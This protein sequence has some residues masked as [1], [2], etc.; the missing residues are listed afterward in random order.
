VETLKFTSE[1][2]ILDFLS[3][4]YK[5]RNNSSIWKLSGQENIWR[6]YGISILLGFPAPFSAGWA[7][8]VSEQVSSKRY[9]GREVTDL[10]GLLGTLQPT[11]Q[12]LFWT[13]QHQPGCFP[14][15]QTRS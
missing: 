1:E 8:P 14:E 3:V 11:T 10:H 12:E 2:Q 9:D 4:N 7:T 13:S 15:L 6:S 5:H